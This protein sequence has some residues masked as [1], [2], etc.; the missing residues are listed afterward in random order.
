MY[1]TVGTSCLLDFYGVTSREFHNAEFLEQIIR[2][3]VDFGGLTN[4]HTASHQ[5]KEQQDDPNLPG[6]ATI[7]AMLS[8][9]I[10]Q[11]ILGLNTEN[12]L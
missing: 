1:V 9:S 3:A 4:L 2:E 5:F 11:Y 6:G 10:Y 8:E 7:F 12:W